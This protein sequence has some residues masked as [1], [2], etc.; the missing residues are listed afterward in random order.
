MAP[1]ATEATALKTEDVKQTSSGTATGRTLLLSPPSLAARPDA[2]NAIL[3]ER[4]RASTDLQ[5]LDRLQMGL[6]QLPESAYRSVLIL[7]D[8]DGSTSHQLLAREV[9]DRV[10]KA[11]APGGRLVSRD[12]T[13]EEQIDSQ[14]RREAILAGFVEDGSA[15]LIKPKEEAIKSVPL[16]FGKK[17]ST[18]AA[19]P[20]TPNINGKRKSGAYEAPAPAGVGFVDFSDDLG[21]PVD[22]DEDLIDE[23][24]LLDEEDLAR[25]ITQR[26]LHSFIV[27]SN[28]IICIYCM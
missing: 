23:D 19:A 5:M 8:P 18:P 15:G 20:L 11:L 28:L 10:F 3:A 2:L 9:L 7:D 13:S 4:D 6:V 16:R 24:T 17:S 1:A 26:R 14:E 21:Q 27:G 25:P 12:T 22:D